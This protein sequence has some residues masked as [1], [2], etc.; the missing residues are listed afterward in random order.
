MAVMPIMPNSC[1]FRVCCLVPVVVNADSGDEVDCE[2][3]HVECVDEGNC[4]LDYGSG[5]V[6]LLIAKNTKGDAEAE[7]NNDE[8]QLDEE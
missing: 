2:T 7:L 6:V 1:H 5:I 4:P 8:C 3:P